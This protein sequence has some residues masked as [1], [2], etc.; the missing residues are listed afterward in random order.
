[1][2]QIL[3]FS[4]VFFTHFFLNTIC[5]KGFNVSFNVYTNLI[6]GIAQSVTGI[7]T[8]NQASSLCHKRTHMPHRAF[9]DNIGSFQR[10]TTSRTGITFDNKQSTISCCAG[11]LRR[12]AFNM[13]DARH[14][15]LSYAWSNITVNCDIRFLIH[16]GAVVSSVT[17]NR[18]INSSV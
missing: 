9:N 13:N 15:I 6:C 16:T 18:H 10:D 11:I 7:A 12:T 14:H 1:M 5:A 3:K 8:N 17:I 2:Q 4:N